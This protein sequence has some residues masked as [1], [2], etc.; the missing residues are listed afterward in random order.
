MGRGKRNGG[1]CRM[2]DSR[3]QN[4]YVNDGSKIGQGESERSDRL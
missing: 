1:R 2:I 3:G 4:G